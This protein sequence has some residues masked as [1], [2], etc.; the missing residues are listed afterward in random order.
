MVQKKFPKAK[1]HTDKV[2]ALDTEIMEWCNLVITNAHNWAIRGARDAPPPARRPPP[3]QDG[4][5]NMKL[6]GESK[7]QNLAHDSSAGDL[8]VRKSIRCF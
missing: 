4:G 5:G 2:I 7:P 1:E 8:R 6:I 3:A